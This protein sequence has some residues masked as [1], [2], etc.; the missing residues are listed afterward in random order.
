MQELIKNS[1][2][3]IKEFSEKYEIPYNSVRQWYNGERKAPEYIK[4]L[5]E[6]IGNTKKETTMH[7]KYVYVFMNKEY[8]NDVVLRRFTDEENVLNC[9]DKFWAR[10]YQ[11]E[12][13]NPS[14]ILIRYTLSNEEQIK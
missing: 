11:E 14:R 10:R 12:F 3:S 6:K 7:P 4:K 9:E 8:N 2:L 5:I 13:E 1:G